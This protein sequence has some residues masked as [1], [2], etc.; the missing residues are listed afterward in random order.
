MLKTM[1]DNM[2]LVMWILVI[3]FLATIVFSW[4]MGGF[5]SGAGLDGVV[6]K[7]GTH[8]VMFDQYNQMVQDKLAKMRQDDPTLEIDDAKVSQARGEVWNDLVRAQLM[9]QYQAKFGIVVSNDEVAYAV[10]NN[11]P[12]YIRTNENFQT[13][14]RFDPA[15]YDQFLRYPNSARILIAI[16][17]DY[18][19]SIGN[20]K[21]IDRIIAPIYITPDEVWDD[22]V[23]KNE[24][25]KAVVISFPANNYPA[26]SAAVSEQAVREYYDNHREDYLAPETRQLS[27]VSVPVIMSQADSN[28]VLELA[29]DIMTWAKE[30]QSFEELAGEYSEDP[31]SAEKG[32]DLGWFTRGRMVTEFDSAAFATPPGEIVG[33]INTRFGAHIIKVE[34]VAIGGEQDSVKARHI[35]LKWEISAETDARAAQIA[36]DFLDAAKLNGFAQTASKLELESTQTPDFQYNKN[37]TISGIGRNLSIMEFAFNSKLDAISNVHKLSMRGQDSYAVFK[38]DKITPKGYTPLADVEAAILSQLLQETREKTALAAA[39]QFRG[40]SAS[41]DELFAIALAESLKVDTSGSHARRDF[42]RPF[43]QDENTAKILL[44]TPVG[45]LAPTLQN[46]RG[47]YLAKVLEK[48]EAD[49]AL[50]ITQKDQ[51]ETNLIRTKQNRVYGDWLALAEKEIGVVDKRYLYYTGF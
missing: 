29:Q 46:A 6:G 5:D 39:E 2:P 10:R 9:E 34:D 40:R 21:V 8:E 38:L 7:I 35:L 42:L 41:P 14:G 32:G 1:R 45:Q 18:R 36:R 47:A 28:R 43:G 23:A 44:K 33:P 30:G 16:E 27:Y 19:N 24:R 25:F 37:G 51:L 15:L 48:T 26:D 3:A 4:G 13:D 31:G 17:N 12:N 22:F 11:P 50:F 20:Q 49:S